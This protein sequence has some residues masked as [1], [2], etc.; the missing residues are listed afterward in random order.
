MSAVSIAASLAAHQQPLADFRSY[1]EQSLRNPFTLDLKDCS[2]VEIILACANAKS[3]LHPNYLSSIGGLLYNIRTLESEYHVKL[4]SVQ[5]T[6]I[7]W[8]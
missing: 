1:L 8:G 4:Q 6:D 2:L 3:K 7:F 5:V